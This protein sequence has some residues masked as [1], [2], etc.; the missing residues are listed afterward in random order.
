MASYDPAL[1]TQT[2]SRIMGPYFLVMGAVL[3]ARRDDLAQLFPAI[4]RDGPLVLIVG[5]FTLIVG[6]AIIAA[7]HH[8]AGAPAIAISLIGVAS[9][10]KGA[11]LMLAPTLGAHIT[12]GFVAS[13]PLALAAAA[14]L[15]TLGA[16]LSF[17]GWIADRARTA[18]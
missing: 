8:W 2:L 14:V 18:S 6:L 4:M 12:A 9:A 5:A 11:M 1:R 17:V 16:W 15:S 7:H 3:F 10:A 13:P